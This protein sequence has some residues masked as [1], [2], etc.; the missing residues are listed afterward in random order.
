MERYS[1]EDSLVTGESTS[2]DRPSTDRGQARRRTEPKQ[3]RAPSPTDP[4]VATDC[5]S[6]SPFAG[7]HVAPPEVSTKT[8]VN[9]PSTAGLAAIDMADLDKLRRW[10]QERGVR[11]D[12]YPSN[13]LLTARELGLSVPFQ[14][15]GFDRHHSTNFPFEGST[16]WKGSPRI[17]SSKS[18]NQ[19]HASKPSVQQSTAHS[20]RCISLCELPDTS[21]FEWPFAEVP[22]S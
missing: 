5:M 9:L 8:T 19:S 13:T 11:R 3:V 18:I 12:L 15:Y 14:T 16:V 20:G 10:F 7:H 6:L 1:A 4:S 22:E 2:V 17:P 21:D